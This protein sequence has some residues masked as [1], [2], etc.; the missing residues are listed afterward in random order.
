MELSALALK[1]L[2]IV[3]VVK[4]IKLKSVQNN[5]MEIRPKINARFSDA[6]QAVAAVCRRWTGNA[7]GQTYTNLT[8]LPD[9]VTNAIILRWK[10]WMEYVS[11]KAT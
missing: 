5:C 2:F 11:N 7:R 3:S 8:K 9:Q 4:P 10:M 6:T 1:R